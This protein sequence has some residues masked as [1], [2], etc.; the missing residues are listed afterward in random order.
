MEIMPAQAR[1][2]GRKKEVLAGPRRP[3]F[4]LEGASALADADV[5]PR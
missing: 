1:D 4:L 2:V 3:E 5:V